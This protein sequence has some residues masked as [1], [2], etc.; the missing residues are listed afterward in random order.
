MNTL[1]NRYSF[2]LGITPFPIQDKSQIYFWHV[3]QYLNDFMEK[4]K[5]NQ[6][7]NTI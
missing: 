4:K 5:I 6:A 7:V 3:D 2:L 1:Y